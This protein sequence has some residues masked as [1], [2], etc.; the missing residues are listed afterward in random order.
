MKIL[1]HHRTLG[2]GAEGIHIREIISAFEQL[3]HQVQV[4]SPVN[5]VRESLDTP[6]EKKKSRKLETIKSFMPRIV[7]RASELLYNLKSF[8]QV[9]RAILQERPDFIYERYA[10]FNFG[11]IRAANKHGIP[12]ILE[13]NT[14]YSLAWE[15][16]DKLYFKRL[17]RSIE[18][19]SI[20]KAHSVITVS[21]DLKKHFLKNG[22]SDEKF[23]VMPNGIDPEQFQSSLRKKTRELY[24]IT[25]SIVIGF[26]GSLRKWHGIDLLMRIIP[27]LVRECDSCRF[28]IVGCG[29]LESVF[30]QFVEKNH[31]EKNVL[32]TGQVS[33]DEIPHLISA[34]DI[35]LMPNSN[36]WGSPMKV[37]EYMA[38]G[39]ATIAPDLGP[40]REIIEDGRNGILVKSGCSNSLKNAILKLIHEPIL[41]EKIGKEAYESIKD[42]YTWL[43]N[44]KRVIEV[45]KHIKSNGGTCKTTN[46]VGL[47]GDT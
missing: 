38:M 30:R 14:P 10:C 8:R 9:S 11:G 13:V 12:V 42:K 23:L 18:F 35:T 6:D 17:A 39:K 5:S 16:Y 2:Q 26:V 21:T 45:A 34:M 40:L 29:E 27:E 33:H 44:A 37:F 47:Q 4:V 24:G 25:E 19:D 20:A 15:N 46:R 7:F 36:F 1:Y 28:L 22:F 3:G 43:N 31:L 32:L 41:R